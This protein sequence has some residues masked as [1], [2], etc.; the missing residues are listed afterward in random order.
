MA[1]PR[2]PLHERIREN[3][4]I[5]GKT[6]CWNWSGTTD[7]CGYG[8]LFIGQKNNYAHR[9]SYQELVGKIPDGAWICHKC[10]NPSCVNPDHLFLGSA[11]INALDMVAKGRNR[12]PFGES[13]VKAKLTDCD[14]LQIRRAVT[15]GISS[16]EIAGAY[17][18]SFK[19]VSKIRNR[20][21]WKHL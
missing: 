2:R 14:V 19:T 21:S 16:Q 18:I 11:K 20:G 8:K 10:D 7:K 12:P 5:D 4:E 15:Y 3:V 9:V 6:G 17:G 13:H 1:P